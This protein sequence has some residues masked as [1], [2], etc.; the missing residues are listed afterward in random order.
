MGGCSVG[1]GELSLWVAV[2][3]GWVVWVG[4]CSGWVVWW[5]CV[6]GCSVGGGGVGGWV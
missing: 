4:W 6:G 3:V 5:V 2:G 1:M